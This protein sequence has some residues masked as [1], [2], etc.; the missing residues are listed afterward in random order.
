[1]GRGVPSLEEGVGDHVAEGFGFH[2][3]VLLEGVEIDLLFHPGGEGLDIGAQSAESHNDVVL[4]F[5]DPLEIVGEG[6][7]LLSESSICGDPDAV[8][9]DHADDGASIVF[10]DRHI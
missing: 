9:A 2:G 6:E 7:H 10:K 1:M 8:F 5:E 4:H 3:L